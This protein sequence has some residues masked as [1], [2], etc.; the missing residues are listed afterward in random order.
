[1]KYSVVF[2]NVRIVALFTGLSRLFGF[3]REMLMAY[4]FGTSLLKSAFDVAFRI[5]NLFRRIFGEGALSAAFIPVYVGEQ[6]AHGKAAANRL[7]SRFISLLA[8]LLSMISLLIM[9]LA[10]MLPRFIPLGE[11]AAEVL[12]LLRIMMPYMVFICLVAFCMAVLNAK[13]HFAV[14]AATP[15]LL[16]LVWILVL[17]FVC[18]HIEDPRLRIHMVGWGIVLAGIVQLAVQFPVLR[19]KGVELHWDAAWNAGAVREV[20]GLMVPAALGMGALQINVVIDGFL[21]LWVAEWAPAA[22]T[23]AE[24]LIYLPLGIFATALGTV[25]LPTFSKYAARSDYAA[26]RHNLNSSM[27]ALLVVM[28]PAA[29]GLIMLAHPIVALVFVWRGGAFYGDSVWQTV[30]ALRFYAPG[31]VVF[32]LYKLM[33]PT[34]YAMKDTR[35]PLRIGLIAVVLNFVMNVAFILT[36]P[37]GYKHAG[38]AAATV[39]SS[40]F[41]GL[42]LAFILRRRIGKIGWPRILK[43]LL[44][45]LWAS[46]VMGMVAGYVWTAAGGGVNGG[47][48]AETV[49]LLAGISVGVVVYFLLALVLFRDDVRTLFRA[50]DKPPK[51]K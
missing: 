33:A 45:T 7:A 25:L 13:G 17:L 32:S 31:L 40:L 21:A 51:M 46:L 47:K 44:R 19:R 48:P 3:F 6:E 22:L 35:T 29:V 43:T 5:P 2:R 27:R 12:P 38:L 28:T 14:P 50:K 15:L 1:M 36:W 30:R 11:R 20:M 23:Y 8:G 41:N 49:A 18:P 26:I 10:F 4:F 9:L 39:L 42:A 34:F 16:N 37:T 24:R